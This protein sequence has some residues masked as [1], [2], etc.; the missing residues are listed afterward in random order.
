LVRLRGP[1]HIY[2]RV[3]LRVRVAQIEPPR[4]LW[5]AQRAAYEYRLSDQDHGEILS[6]HWPPDGVSHVQ[7]P[8]LHLEPAAEVGRAALLTAHLSTGP[9]SLWD[10][11]RLA[12]ES[13]SAE[14]LRPDRSQVLGV[15]QPTIG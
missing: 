4:G 5:D 7:S 9:V 3:R 8:H 1:E 15:M 2:L 12:V 13:F 14:T 10:G 11:L 6:Y